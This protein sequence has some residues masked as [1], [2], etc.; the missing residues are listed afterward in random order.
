MTAIRWISNQELFASFGYARA[1]QAIGQLLE[2]GFDPASDKQRTFVNFEHGQ[3]L[4]M[5][6]EIGDFAGLKF[7]TVAPENKKHNLD[8]IQG[9]YSLLTR[10]P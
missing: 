3:G 1:I 9:I 8:R 6:S 5:P 2:S 10:R 4:V 7:V